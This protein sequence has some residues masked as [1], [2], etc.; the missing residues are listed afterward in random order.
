M[1]CFVGWRWS[2]LELRL[3]RWLQRNGKCGRP[4][5][6]NEACEI[7]VRGWGEIAIVVANDDVEIGTCCV[8]LYRGRCVGI[9]TPQRHRSRHVAY[10]RCDGGSGPA[11]LCGDNNGSQ[12]DMMLFLMRV[13]IMVRFDPM[14]RKYPDAATRKL[15]P[16]VFG[17]GT[18]AAVKG[19]LLPHVPTTPAADQQNTR[20]RADG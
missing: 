15:E 20:C 19:I 16:G 11:I 12:G 13:T 4:R 17:A 2:C 3:A 7:Y 9:E 5:V 10:G 8:G 14:N 18:F 6:D 1:M